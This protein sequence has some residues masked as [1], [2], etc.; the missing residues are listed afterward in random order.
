MAPNWLTRLCHRLTR[1][2]PRAVRCPFC[3][4]RIPLVAA[5]TRPGCPYGCVIG[6]WGA[7]LTMREKTQA[8]PPTHARDTHHCL[9][10]KTQ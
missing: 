9:E 1:A 2:R 3:Q 6:P 4:A 8:L 7:W 10:E 5:I